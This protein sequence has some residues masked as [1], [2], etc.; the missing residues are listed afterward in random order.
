MTR[1]DLMARLSPP[2]T[3]DEW[4]R[5]NAAQRRWLICLLKLVNEPSTNGKERMQ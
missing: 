2:M 1:K 4:R 5:L 3:E